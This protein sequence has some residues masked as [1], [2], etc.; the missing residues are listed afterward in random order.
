MSKAKIYLVAY[1]WKRHFAFSL[2][3]KKEFNCNEFCACL[4]II[5]AWYEV[6]L[7]MFHR[8]I[9]AWSSLTII[10]IPE[11]KNHSQTCHKSSLIAFAF[12]VWYYQALKKTEQDKLFVFLK[13]IPTSLLELEISLISDCF[14][15]DNN[16]ILDSHKVSK[17]G[18]NPFTEDLVSCCEY[19][20][21]KQCLLESSSKTYSNHTENNSSLKNA[22]SILNI[23]S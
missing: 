19:A 12:I 6:E 7:S 9:R 11:G 16:L 17:E 15:H 23:Y 3:F 18:W 20:F 22:A 4:C 1:N 13:E 21:C 8:I 14:Q 10:T 5:L 2:P